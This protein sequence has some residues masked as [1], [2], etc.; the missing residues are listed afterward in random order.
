[1]SVCMLACLRA[2]L[3]GAWI[4]FIDFAGGMFWNGLLLV[5]Y[6]LLLRVLFKYR[7]SL[8]FLYALTRIQREEGSV[9]D[10]LNWLRVAGVCGAQRNGR[11]YCEHVIRAFMAPCSSCSWIY[12]RQPRENL[13]F[14]F[15]F[16]YY[17]PAACL[18]SSSSNGS[19]I[20]FWGLPSEWN[21]NC[22]QEEHFTD[23]GI[24]PPSIPCLLTKKK[25]K[26]SNRQTEERIERSKAPQLLN[27][28]VISFVRSLELVFHFNLLSFPV[29][30]FLFLYVSS[31]GWLVDRLSFHLSIYLPLSVCQTAL[32]GGT[33][34]FV[35]KSL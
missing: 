24:L 8:P 35:P 26:E 9:F 19:V 33:N 25:K 7:P 32:D 28:H 16:S 31:L 18:S 34:K 5:C 29:S 20:S 13:F 21:L 4:W 14:F 17:L 22:V 30:S 6:S 10:F 23:W 11:V 3:L 27:H 1:M 15:C 12:V 2:E